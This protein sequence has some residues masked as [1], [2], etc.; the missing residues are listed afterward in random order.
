MTSS[1]YPLDFVVNTPTI[2]SGTNILSTPITIISDHVSP[3]G[4][5][6]LRLNFSFDITL[7]SMMI[8]VFDGAGTT[9][10]GNLNADNDTV[11]QSD[12]YYRFDIDVEAGDTINLQSSED[13]TTVNHFRAHLV[14]FGA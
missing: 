6:I 4:G 8:S 14:Q 3:G 2:N 10:I 13:I 1:I 5:G 11:I 9:F 7:A 12:G